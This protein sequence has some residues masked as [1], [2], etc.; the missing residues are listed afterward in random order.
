MTYFVLP[1]T[2]GD[3]VTTANVNRLTADDAHVHQSKGGWTQY[4]QSKNWAQSQVMTPKIGDYHLA[5]QSSASGGS[6][7][8]TGAGTAA[9]PADAATEYSASLWVAQPDGL[10]VQL[11]YAAFDSGGTLIGSLTQIDSASSGTSDWTFLD[12]TFTTPASTAY[13]A[14]VPSFSSSAADQ[15]C[16]VDK[17][18]FRTG[19][20]SSFVRSF[21]VIGDLDIEA[22]LSADDWTPAGNKAIV[23]CYVSGD[24]AGYQW[25]LLTSGDLYVIYGNGSVNRSESA[26]LGTLVDGE[27]YTIRTV[28]DVSAGSLTY[29]LNGAQVA[30]DVYSAGA[31]APS[32]SLLAVGG[33]ANETSCW[34]GTLEYVTV[35]DGIGGPIVAKASAANAAQTLGS[36]LSDSDTWVGLEDSRTWTVS[37]SGSDI[38]LGSSSSRLAVLGVS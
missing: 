31:G 30:T 26:S 36:A 22:K 2:S 18:C 24:Q 12:G 14:I 33:A 7:A 25:F 16:Y 38:S 37:T 6:Y 1:G 19:A 8:C 35:R 32:T 27:T 15:W 23:D 11:S 17:A 9:E 21:R 34:D 20:D 28:H 5:F 10:A 3:L 4:F 29:Y 13:V